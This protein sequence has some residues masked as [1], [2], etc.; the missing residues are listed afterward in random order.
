MCVTLECRSIISY[1]IDTQSND[2]YA[3]VKLCVAHE[4]PHCYHSGFLILTSTLNSKVTDAVRLASL[5]FK[6]R[7]HFKLQNTRLNYEM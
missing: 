4:D 2:T 1:S 5:S 7:G 6:I 3:Q